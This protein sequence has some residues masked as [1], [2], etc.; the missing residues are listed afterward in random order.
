VQPDRQRDLVVPGTPNDDNRGP[1][2][3]VSS[4]AGTVGAKK[5][6]DFLSDRRVDRHRVDPSGHQGGQAPC[7]SLFFLELPQPRP[8]GRI[9][10]ELSGVHAAVWRVHEAGRG[11][12]LGDTTASLPTVISISS[13]PPGSDSV[14]VR[15]S[16]RR[17]QAAIPA[18][19]SSR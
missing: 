11:R 4:Y 8:V 2:R 10:A 16:L 1:I 9:E 7:R 18:S 17:D 19:P 3:L 13:I 12:V 14:L 15:G 6:A 5:S